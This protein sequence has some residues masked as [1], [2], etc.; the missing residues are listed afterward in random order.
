MNESTSFDEI[1]NSLKKSELIQEDKFIRLYDA[2]RDETEIGKGEPK[3][4]TQGQFA[5]KIQNLIYGLPQYD[6]VLLKLLEKDDGIALVKESLIRYIQTH[7]GPDNIHEIKVDLT[8]KVSLGAALDKMYLNISDRERLQQMFNYPKDFSYAFL[9]KE[10]E[11]GYVRYVD[12]FDVEVRFFDACLGF[13]EL[14]E[15][16]LKYIKMI[17]A[18]HYTLGSEGDIRNNKQNVIFEAPMHALLKQSSEYIPLMVECFGLFDR[19]H[20]VSALELI[21]FV[22]NRYAGEPEMIY[23]Y[24]AVYSRA[25]ADYD[26]FD[27]F[28]EEL[29]KKLAEKSFRDKYIRLLAEDHLASSIAMNFECRDL[30]GYDLEDEIGDRTWEDY[31]DESAIGDFLKEICDKEEYEELT[32]SFNQ[33]I[34]DLIHNPALADHSLYPPSYEEITGLKLN[35]VGGVEKDQTPHASVIYDVAG[36]DFIRFEQKD[37]LILADEGLVRI[38]DFDTKKQITVRNLLHETAEVS[39]MHT[40]HDIKPHSPVHFITDTDDII[41]G[42]HL[43]SGLDCFKIKAPSKG[44]FLSGD[45]TRLVMILR[46]KGDDFEPDHDYSGVKIDVDLSKEERNQ[47]VCFDLKTM[48]EVSRWK[49]KKKYSDPVFTKD[50]KYFMVLKDSKL[51]IFDVDTGELIKKTGKLGDYGICLELAASSDSQKAI[52]DNY[53]YSLPDAEF[54]NKINNFT[55]GKIYVSRGDI[56]VRCGDDAFT[57]GMFCFSDVNTGEELGRI[58]VDKNTYTPHTVFFSPCGRYFLADTNDELKVWDIRALFSGAEQEEFE[59]EFPSVPI[60]SFVGGRVISSSTAKS[61]YINENCTPKILHYETGRF[62]TETSAESFCESEELNNPELID[63]ESAFIPEDGDVIGVRFTPEALGRQRIFAFNVKVTFPETTCSETGD[64]ITSR[65]WLQEAEADCNF[66]AGYQLS[67]EDALNTGTWSIEISTIE[68]EH[69]LL[70]KLFYLNKPFKA[71][72]YQV[73]K[74]FFGLYADES[75]AASPVSE[76]ARIIGKPGISFGLQFAFNCPDCED[77]YSF[78]GEIDHPEKEDSVTG[79]MTTKSTRKI[80]LFNGQSFGYFHRF[81]SEESVVAGEWTFRIKDMEQDRVL[82]EETLEILSAA[83]VE[84]PEFKLLDKGVYLPSGP[85]GLYDN[86]PEPGSLTRQGDPDP[87]ALEKNSVFGFCYR[88]TNLITPKMLA[89]KIYHPLVK[90]MFGEETAEEFLFKVPDDSPQF[91]G[92][93]I[94]MNK[95]ILEGEWKIR[96]WENEI[97]ET[98]KPIYE[99]KFNTIK[100]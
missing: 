91:I 93:V 22:F 67:S 74:K 71:V 18:F 72:D 69:F 20:D 54:V 29:C 36:A 28:E 81:I 52:V 5:G 30:R 17:N 16:V 62:R 40:T 31:L 82:L 11:E 99:T 45:G 25:C 92:W 21:P 47:V 12:E 56:V 55:Y 34:Q 9:L 14:K 51:L 59:F 50:G 58:V 4:Y 73:K 86:Y 44:I 84:E 89:V 48:T 80:A 27:M 3:V 24:A 33:T 2:L 23:L 65:E 43:S 8:D 63:P 46:K 61:N 68:G 79:M 6:Q 77:K 76:T 100:G 19:W 42:W 49:Y 60:V 83:E 66:F 94:D 97:D 35:R 87:I 70:R 53:V 95:Y 85:V 96:V 7:Y 1:Y 41:Q 64:R 78:M 57:E 32:D 38:V 39:S 37:Y 26:Y 98:Q 88:F 15:K 10:P 75:G 90:S 13:P